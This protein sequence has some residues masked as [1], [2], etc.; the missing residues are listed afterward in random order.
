MIRLSRIYRI[1]LHLK[2]YTMLTKLN[3]P[4][5]NQPLVIQPQP[6]QPPNPEPDPLEADP[7]RYRVPYPPGPTLQD[8]GRALEAYNNLL[9]AKNKNAL[10]PYAPV[11]QALPMSL[12]RSMMYQTHPV[13]ESPFIQAPYTTVRRPLLEA[14]RARM[15][16]DLSTR[17]SAPAVSR[18]GQLPIAVLDK[19]VVFMLLDAPPKIRPRATLRNFTLACRRFRHTTTPYVYQHAVLRGKG[20]VGVYARLGVGKHVRI[21]TIQFDPY[22]PWSPYSILVDPALYLEPQGSNTT[23]KRGIESAFPHLIQMTFVARFAPDDA[24]TMWHANAQILGAGYGGVKFGP[25]N[26][27]NIYKSHS[28][29]AGKLALFTPARVKSVTLDADIPEFVSTFALLFIKRAADSKTQ[30]RLDIVTR[31]EEAVQATECAIHSYAARN[32]VPV[33]V[34][35][36]MYGPSYGTSFFWNGTSRAPPPQAVWRRNKESNKHELPEEILPPTWEELGPGPRRSNRKSTSPYKNP[37]GSSPIGKRGELTSMVKSAG[38]TPMYAKDRVRRREPSPEP[39]VDPVPAPSKIP[40][41]TPEI[42][43]VPHGQKCA[44]SAGRTLAQFPE[45]LE[46]A[47]KQVNDSFAQFAGNTPGTKRVQFQGEDAEYPEFWQFVNNLAG[48]Q[49]RIGVWHTTARSEVDTFVSAYREK[50]F[51]SNMRA[52][53][54]Q[55]MK[56]FGHDQLV[57]ERKVSKARIGKARQVN[58]D[59]N[60]PKAGAKSSTT[61]VDD[62]ST[63]HEGRATKRVRIA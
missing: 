12:A 15:R 23:P 51:G 40:E 41:S 25:V 34:A 3:I 6:V 36:V 13:P 62:A 4:A 59:R 57:V 8:E 44:W 50:R 22:D 56:E 60:A 27:S 17:T 14:W 53:K 48:K 11:V 52:F 28:F 63:S 26:P 45:A 20:D 37:D 33:R 29:L 10:R 32:P 42:D 58:T 1:P 46:S 7:I 31:R 49:P 39:E 43:N 30:A 61:H 35:L 24:R 21:L 55:M 18:G 5:P 16:L 19:I 54:L 9:V 38:R 47:F 2:L